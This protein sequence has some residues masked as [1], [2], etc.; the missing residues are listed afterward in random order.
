MIFQQKYPVAAPALKSPKE[1]GGEGGRDFDVIFKSKGIPNQFC[2]IFLTIFADSFYLG[3]T[4][5]P[6]PPRGAAAANTPTA[7]MQTKLIRSGRAATSYTD[8]D[9]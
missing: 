5:P 7:T 9:P 3:G 6:V 8:L 1:V 4:N 2:A